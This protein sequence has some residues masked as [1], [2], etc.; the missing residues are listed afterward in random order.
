MEELSSRN[1][2]M[3]APSSI[4]FANGAVYLPGSKI[5]LQ[6]EVEM[7]TLRHLLEELGLLGDPDKVRIPG[8]VYDRIVD[9]T[10]DFSEDED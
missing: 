5:I 2:G 6:Q 7:P 4:P 3:I 10:E 8:Q 9:E 1:S